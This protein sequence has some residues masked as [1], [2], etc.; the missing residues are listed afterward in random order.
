MFRV[1]IGLSPLAHPVI[2]VQLG[3]DFIV[4]LYSVQSAIIA[5]INIYELDFCEYVFTQNVLR[6]F[7]IDKV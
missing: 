7:F 5:T 4:G 6:R 3:A 1:K 2:T